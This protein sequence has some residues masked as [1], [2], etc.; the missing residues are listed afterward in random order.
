MNLLFYLVLRQLFALRSLQ[1]LLHAVAGSVG[2]AL[3]G[4]HDVHALDVVGH[5]ERLRRAGTL[6][7]DADLERAEAVQLHALAVLQL[8]AHGLHQL[9][10]HSQD[11]GLLHGTVA[12]HD[13]SQL[14][15]VDTT[16]RHH[17]GIPLAAAL[18]SYTLVLMQSVKYT[19]N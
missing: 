13:F 5:G 6:R 12:L 15:G 1:E 4:E 18:R 14:A 17:A 3:G 11:I 8:V 19:H 16:R 2:R 10:E 7:G 9:V